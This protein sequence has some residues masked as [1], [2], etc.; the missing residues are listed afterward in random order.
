MSIDTQTADIPE[1]SDFVKNL[2]V[3]RQEA[4]GFY[5]RLSEIQ[6]HCRKLTAEHLPPI[7]AQNKI[8]SDT[9]DHFKHIMINQ[10][11]E[12]YTRFN[13]NAQ[14]KVFDLG[15]GCGRLAFPF[16]EL[17]GD[18][19]H[20]W[21]ADVWPEGIE[22]CNRLLGR[23]NVNFHVIPAANNYYFDEFDG[24]KKNNFR[25]DF[26]PDNSL[27]LAFAISVFTH[28]IEEDTRAYL[29]E[30]RRALKPEGCAYITCF[31]I[32]K[33]FHEYVERTGKHK[34]VEKKAP[35]YYQAYSGQDFFG[36]YTLNKWQEMLA[37]SDLEI[38]SLERGTWAEKPSG[39]NFQ[40]TLVVMPKRNV[41]D[42]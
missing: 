23:E 15:C 25:L 5:A 1:P 10:F 12:L 30:F 22:I 36:A 7:P 38:I 32:D 16:S 14:S 34:A 6:T 29:A 40:D 33:F 42:L 37:D 35:G 2:K 8:G 28:L 3:T 18:G 11:S 41:D 21:G 17:I 39:R 27:D 31:I 24:R 4:A 9:V 13:L 20:Y 26:L 19:G